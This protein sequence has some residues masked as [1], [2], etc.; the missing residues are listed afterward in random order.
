MEATTRL[1]RSG[2][3]LN[4][5]C[6]ITALSDD[7][8]VAIFKLAVHRLLYVNKWHTLTD[9]LLSTSQLTDEQGNEIHREARQSDYFKINIPAQGTEECYDW[10]KIE[11]LAYERNTIA[12]SESI[13]LQAR[14]DDATSTFVVF[15]R[16]LNVTASVY[17]GEV[18]NTESHTVLDKVRNTKGTVGAIL[19][20]SRIQWRSFVNG[21]LG[22]LK[23]ME[24][25]YFKDIT[26]ETLVVQ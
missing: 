6:T 9:S 10:V 13:T 1:R 17:G 8:A 25:Y 19:G 3:K 16:G 21:I 2:T 7:F 26:P 24:R 5:D 4:I 22:D 12:P 11:K 18:P 14:L 15:R 20:R 23:E